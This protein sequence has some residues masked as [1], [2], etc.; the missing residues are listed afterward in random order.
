[1]IV[2]SKGPLRPLGWI[3]SS[4]DDLRKYPSAVRREIGIDLMVVQADAKP[5][6]AKPLT[7]AGAGVMEI[8]ENHQGDTYRA[9]YLAK[10]KECSFVLHCFQK[11]SKKGKAMPKHDLELVKARMKEAIAEHNRL[12]GRSKK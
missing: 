4:K 2:G 11:K 8:V 12:Y 7:S 3:G 1:M 9:V 10:F 5:A 6:S